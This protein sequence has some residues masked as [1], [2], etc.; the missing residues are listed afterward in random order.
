M[1]PS[2]ARRRWQRGRVFLYP[3][4][5]PTWVGRFYEDVFD[6]ATGQTRRVYRSV[7]LGTLKELPTER[8]A[9]RTL[10]PY[11]EKV[12]SLTSQPSVAARFQAFA[13]RWQQLAL[14]NL[15]PSTQAA[16]RSV[17]RTHLTPFFGEYYLWQISPELIQSFVTTLQTKVSAKTVHNAFRLLKSLWKIAPP[18]GLRAA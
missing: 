6:P 16:V 8:L 3:G 2:L 4:R 7:V 15:K 5:I 18:V 17:L 13:E 11:V 9:R 10:Q 12:N 1:Q 14:P